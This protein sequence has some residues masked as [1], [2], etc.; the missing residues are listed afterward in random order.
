F[1]LGIGGV[2][3]SGNQYMSWIELDDLVR[4]IQ[5]AL[6]A[7][8]ING[9]VNAVAPTPVTNR[10]F[11]KTLGR[12]LH[13]PTIFPMPA[14]AARAAFG[15]MADE[16]LLSGVRVEPRALNSARFEFHYPQLEEALRHAVT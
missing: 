6:A 5:F 8:A 14:F 15:E 9:P 7:A 16:M 4:V 2:I 12:V 13:R 10:E 11:T 3:G 1:R